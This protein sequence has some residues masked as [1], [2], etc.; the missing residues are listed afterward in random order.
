MSMRTKGETDRGLRP[1]TLNLGDRE[2]RELLTLAA[3]RSLEEDRPIG[4][5]E[6]ARSLILPRPDAS[7]PEA[8]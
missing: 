2:R 4:I 5:S 7:D 1:V 3:A 8:A 6:I